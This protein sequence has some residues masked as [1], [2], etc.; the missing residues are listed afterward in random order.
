MEDARD[1]GALAWWK[2][3]QKANLIPIEVAG[4]FRELQQLTGEVGALGE[5]LE[6]P[7]DPRPGQGRAHRPAR[8][9]GRRCVHL[10]PAHAMSERSRMRDVA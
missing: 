6:S 7:Q 8:D 4:R 10:H 2:P 3:Y 5:Q 9:E 1:A